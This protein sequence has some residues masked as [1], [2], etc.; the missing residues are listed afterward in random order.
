MNLFRDEET[1]AEIEIFKQAP[2]MQAKRIEYARNYKK[3]AIRN[4]SAVP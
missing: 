2:D 4:R 3:H 1:A